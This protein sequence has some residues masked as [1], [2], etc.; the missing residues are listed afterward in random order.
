MTKY[1]WH[2][3]CKRDETVNQVGRLL[4]D[5]LTLFPRIAVDLG[6]V[7]YIRGLEGD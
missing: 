4:W 1:E 5:V 6:V 7:E 2:C 3:M